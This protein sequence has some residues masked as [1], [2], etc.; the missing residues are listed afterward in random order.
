MRVQ[1][2]IAVLAAAVAGGVWMLQGQ[3][4]AVASGAEGLDIAEGEALYA[5]ACAACHGAQLEGQPDWR[6]RGPD[7]RLPAPPHD[8]T[9]HTWHHSDSLLF[10]YTKLGGKALMAQQGMEFDSGMSGFGDSL[11]D[12]QIR[13]VL[14]Y[15]RSTWP[16]HVKEA[17][18]ART[19]AENGEN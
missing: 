1:V 16:E 7:G 5:E 9:G 19:N 2:I 8:E 17:Q 10:N 11:T 13:N 4:P 12:Q 3:D 15:I 14:G 18:K 6:T